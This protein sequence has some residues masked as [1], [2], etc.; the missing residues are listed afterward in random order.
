MGVVGTLILVVFT[1]PF[2]HYAQERAV[3]SSST[4][5]T[6]PVQ[7]DSCPDISHAMRNERSGC[8]RH[9]FCTDRD[10]RMPVLSFGAIKNWSRN[11]L[12]LIEF[13]HFRKV[14]FTNENNHLSL[15]F[16]SK[17]AVILKRE[18]QFL[19]DI[20]TYLNSRRS[21]SSKVRS[22]EN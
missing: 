2:R 8:V 11:F 19:Y 9:T 7:D 17:V 5:G 21:L 6:V 14:L 4:T 3:V 13:R 15:S 18:K 10:E 16:W 1:S 22:W 12:Y 20:L